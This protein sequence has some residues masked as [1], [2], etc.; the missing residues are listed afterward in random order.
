M[1]LAEHL[2]QVEAPRRAAGHVVLDHALH[3]AG[4]G[5]QEGLDR[6]LAH[7]AVG[8]QP[9]VGRGGAQRRHPGERV[10]VALEHAHDAGAAAGGEV[11]TARE[12]AQ[13]QADVRR[14]PAPGVGRAQGREGAD[15][16]GGHDAVVQR[17]GA[18]DGVRAARGHADDREAAEAEAVGEVLDV[19]GEVGDPAPRARVRAPEARAADRQVADAELGDEQVEL[20][21]AAHRRPDG[22]V[23]VEDRHAVVVAA[24]RPCEPTVVGEG[25]GAFASDGGHGENPANRHHTRAGLRLLPSG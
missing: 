8:Q 19:G 2:A 1:D 14:H 7:L 5:G 4:R 9:A 17:P 10:R 23:Q 16:G 18:G 20:G 25:H 11:G 6:G 21:R 13:P 15:G 3:A 24:R 12:G 22:A